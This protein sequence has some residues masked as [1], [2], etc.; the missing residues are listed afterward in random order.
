MK[1]IDKLT[2]EFF[3]SQF[4]KKKKL[5]EIYLAI[6]KKKIYNSFQINV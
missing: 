3:L 5:F 2:E 1:F 6:F 4:K